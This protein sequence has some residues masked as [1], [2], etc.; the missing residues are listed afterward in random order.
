MKRELELI[1]KIILSIED[2]ESA[3]AP[4][5]M[6]F[7]VYTAAQIGYHS[8]LVVDAGLAR[9]G[10]TTHMGS[11]GPEAVISS[12]T[13]TGHEFAEA[14]R[15][16]T[17]WNTAIAVVREKTGTVTVAVLTQV[18]VNLMKQALGLP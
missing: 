11:D 16:E 6:P 4:R 14:A 5:I 2:S 18:L 7:D 10:E 12:L 15:N 1:R 13:W 9:G 8:W 3:W 17:R